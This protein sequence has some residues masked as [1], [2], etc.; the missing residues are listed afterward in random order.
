MKRESVQLD[1][2]EHGHRYEVQTTEDV[3]R[4]KFLGFRRG[5]RLTLRLDNGHDKYLRMRDVRGLYVSPLES[6]K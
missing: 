5:G 4:G 6:P 1:D 3:Y 2:L